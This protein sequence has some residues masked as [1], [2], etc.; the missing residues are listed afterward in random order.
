MELEFLYNTEITIPVIQIVLLLVLSTGAL[1]FGKVKIALLVNY[2][3]ALYWGFFLNKDQILELIGD[4]QYL[5]WMYF[6]L[7]I[8]VAILALIGFL[9]HKAD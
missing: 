8:V 1:F 9:S 2:V 3:F 7:G 5:M 6:G 4:S